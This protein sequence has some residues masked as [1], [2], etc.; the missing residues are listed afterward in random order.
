MDEIQA[1]LR[2][3][4]GA[5]LTEQTLLTIQAY[6][7]SV[8]N[9]FKQ[10]GIILPPFTLKVEDNVVTIVFEDLNNSICVNKL[11]KEYKEE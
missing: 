11:N 4:F 8:V 1:H 7:N 10:Q 9:D 5:P 3:F 2:K 6:M